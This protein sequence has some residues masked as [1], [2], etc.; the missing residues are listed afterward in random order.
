MSST[1]YPVLPEDPVIGVIKSFDEVNNTYIGFHLQCSFFNI[2]DR[3]DAIY[4]VD[5]LVN[6]EIVKKNSCVDFNNGQGLSVLREEELPAVVLVEE[7]SY[8]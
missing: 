5:W 8:N 4:E 1:D 6:D 2:T 7:V 3:P